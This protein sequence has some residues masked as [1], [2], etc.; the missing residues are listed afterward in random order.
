[1]PVGSVFGGHATIM[2][3]CLVVEDD[4]LF[5]LQNRNGAVA[6]FVQVGENGADET[7]VDRC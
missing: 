4:T 2:D 6:R 7:T 3:A 1:V 5:S